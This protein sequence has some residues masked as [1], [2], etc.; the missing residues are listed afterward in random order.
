MYYVSISVAAR[1]KAW[2]VF[3]RSV[4]GIL[5][6]NPTQGMDVCVHLFCVQVAA[7]R[8]ADPLS[9]DSFR[10]YID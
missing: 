6:S 7:L 5:D 1:F 3:A 9:K 2:T 8:R 4:T 10:P